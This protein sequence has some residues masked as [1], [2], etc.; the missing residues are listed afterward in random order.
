MMSR[1]RPCSTRIRGSTCRWRPFQRATPRRSQV[2]PIVAVEAEACCEG[3][4]TCG[5]EGHRVASPAFRSFSEDTQNPGSTVTLTKPT[6][7]V[8][9]DIVLHCIN[10][11]SSVSSVPSGFTLKVDGGGSGGYFTRVYWKRAS[12]EPTSWQYTF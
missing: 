11:S 3:G 8:D 5:G 10:Y 12:S 9:N 6:G 2:P 7:T 1:A 4:V